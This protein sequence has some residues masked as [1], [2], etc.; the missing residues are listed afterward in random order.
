MQEGTANAVVGTLSA[1]DPDAGETITY[2]LAANPNNFFSITGN[3]LKT[4]AAIS[5]ASYPTV[6]IQVPAA[7]LSCRSTSLV[8]TVLM[9]LLF[10]PS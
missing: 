10:R 4:A 9:P 3:T 6:S 1:V 8:P 2:S 7:V 5:F